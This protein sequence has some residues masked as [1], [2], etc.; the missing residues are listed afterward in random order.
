MKKYLLFILVFFPSCLKEENVVY[1]SKLFLC[2]NTGRVIE[3]Y[4]D[5]LLMDEIKNGEE[6]W[7]YSIRA[8]ANYE[9][10]SVEKIMQ[11]QGW[12]FKDVSIYD[13]SDGGRRFL[14]KWTFTERNEDGKQ[15]YRLSDSEIRVRHERIWG[16]I[17][18]GYIY[19]FSINP[20][21]VE[22]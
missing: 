6:V 19:S 14:K 9:D 16:R 22:L 17:C 10:N 15:L 2:N 8:S 1:F 13:V 12:K 7:L 11:K 20:E 3:V 5:D 4:K 18:I 21:D